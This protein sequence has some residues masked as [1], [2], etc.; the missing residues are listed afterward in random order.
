MVRRADVDLVLRRLAVTHTPGYRLTLKRGTPVDVRFDGDLT[1]TRAVEVEGIELRTLSPAD[2]VARLAVRAAGS[3]LLGPLADLDRALRALGG[4][5]TRDL[6][7]ARAG[8]E[9]E[10]AL[11]AL[12]AAQALLGAPVPAQPDST[13]ALSPEGPT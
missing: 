4:S 11:G 12:A 7:T 8:K 5:V 6:L 13:R 3:S 2:T 1:C 10:A 9:R